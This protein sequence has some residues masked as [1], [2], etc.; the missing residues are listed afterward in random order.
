MEAIM[1]DAALPQRTRLYA[2]E[3]KV[4]DVGPL[5]AEVAPSL[6]GMR[7]CSCQ[8]EP[9]RERSVHGRR[10]AALAVVAAM[11]ISGAFAVRGWR[12]RSGLHEA[13]LGAEQGA[14]GAAAPTAA[15][16]AV[17][18]PAGCDLELDQVVMLGGKMTGS[19]TGREGKRQV[20]NEPREGGSLAL[21]RRLGF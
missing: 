14:L 3:Q 9:P 13:A 7:K 21:A 16:T 4:T 1:N 6:E 15:S 19:A 8:G 17:T 5:A 20:R 10:V 12:S 11:T 2:P 18:P